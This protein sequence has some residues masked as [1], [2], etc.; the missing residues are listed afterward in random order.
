MQHRN[1]VLRKGSILTLPGL[2]LLVLAV[3]WSAHAGQVHVCVGFELPVPVAVVS[4]PLPVVVAPALVVVQ[5]P[6]VWWSTPRR[7]SYG[8]TRHD[9]GVACTVPG[10]PP[11]GLVKKFNGH[12]HAYWQHHLHDD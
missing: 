3:P 12:K 10:P 2:C 7:W 11:A 9:R 8:G 6:P 4:A 1:T 5:R